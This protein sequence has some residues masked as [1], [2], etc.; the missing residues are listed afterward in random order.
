MEL[1]ASS[2]FA[3][4]IVC[5]TVAGRLLAQAP[6]A[7]H[8]PP[9]ARR[10]SAE[11]RG[12]HRRATIVREHAPLVFPQ[13]REARLLSANLSG[14]P[15]HVAHVEPRVWRSEL[16]RVGLRA[17]HPALTENDVAAA[18]LAVNQSSCLLY[19]SPSPRDS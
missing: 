17:R 7:A 8:N 12:I 10:R 14:D 13:S 9:S 5:F 6:G 1:A 4:N 11:E 3:P 15:H 16:L 18:S 19:T 2:V